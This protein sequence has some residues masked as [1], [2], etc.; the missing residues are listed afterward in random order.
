LAGPERADGLIR[1]IDIRRIAR[2]SSARLRTDHCRTGF[3]ARF[4]IDSRDVDTTR[5]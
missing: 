3:A 5:E 2:S 4:S 1:D